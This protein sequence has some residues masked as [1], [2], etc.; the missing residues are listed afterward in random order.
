MVGCLD[1]VIKVT[2]GRGGAL[3]HRCT[4]RVTFECSTCQHTSSTS[5][6]YSSFDNSSTHTQAQSVSVRLCQHSRQPTSW[7]RA[8]NYPPPPA[9]RPRPHLRKSP[10]RNQDLET[11]ASGFRSKLT[12]EIDPTP[13]SFLPGQKACR[14]L[15]L[16][17]AGNNCFVPT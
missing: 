10:T 7:F 13:R 9:P 14:P 11:P 1:S 3:K 17:V 2:R 8:I 5:Y 4:Q 12:A 16:T 15:C 6:M